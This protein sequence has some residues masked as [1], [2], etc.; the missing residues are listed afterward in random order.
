[1]PRSSSSVML[2]SNGRSYFLSEAITRSRGNIV[3]PFT[4]VA[5]L[6]P[7]TRTLGAIQIL[8]GKQSCDLIQKIEVRRDVHFKC[9]RPLLVRDGAGRRR[10]KECSRVNEN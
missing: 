3:E 8:V 6:I 2:C 10:R 7:F 4:T 1:M 5:G 9:L